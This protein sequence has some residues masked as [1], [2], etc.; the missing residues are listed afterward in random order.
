MSEDKIAKI[1]EKIRGIMARPT[2]GSTPAWHQEVAEMRMQ[3]EE[4]RTGKKPTLRPYEDAN[5]VRL[6]D[7]AAAAVIVEEHAHEEHHEEPN[8]MAVFFWL[9][10]FTLIE[11][12]LSPVFH[13]HGLPLW[14]LLAFFASLKAVAVALYY[15][16]LKWEQ[17]IMKAILFLPIALIVLLLVMVIPDAVSKF[18]TVFQ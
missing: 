7:P 17:T 3:I 5:L 9:T 16:H 10:L 11:L 1:E 4:I 15:M 6:R 14:I 13:V 12:G 8:Y 2:Y 18:Q